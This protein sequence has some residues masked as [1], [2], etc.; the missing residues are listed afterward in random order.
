MAFNKTVT[1]QGDSTAYTISSNVKKYTLKDLGF[2][3]TKV[4]N[5]SLKRSLDPKS[6]FNSSIE[7]KVMI[8]STLDGFKMAAV[9]SKG[10]REVNLFKM[11]RADEFAEQFHYLMESFVERDVFE[12]V[13]D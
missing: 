2:Q 3:E 4:G 5:F 8:N 11:D 6:P 7:L 13:A 9:A 12:T 1:L 10:T